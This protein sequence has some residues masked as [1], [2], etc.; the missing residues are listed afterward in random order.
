[1]M[2]QIAW[3]VC[4]HHDVIQRKNSKT[5]PNEYVLHP[6]FFNLIPWIQLCDQKNL[7]FVDC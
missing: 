3:N 7:T 4:L 6:Y 1:M 5:W 2:P